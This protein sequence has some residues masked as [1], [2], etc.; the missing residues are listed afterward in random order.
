MYVM[1]VMLQL[2]LICAAIQHTTLLYTN[3][4]HIMEFDNEHNLH[5]VIIIDFMHS[6]F[7]NSFLFILTFILIFFSL[8]YQSPLNKYIVFHGKWLPYSVCNKSYRQRS[9]LVIHKKLS[10]QMPNICDAC[11]KSFLGAVI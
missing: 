2:V 11:K 1:L 3:Y 5:F 4:G 10:A 8:L 6:L 9:H 7:L